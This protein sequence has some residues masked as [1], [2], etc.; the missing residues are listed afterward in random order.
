MRVTGYFVIP[1][2]DLNPHRSKDMRFFSSSLCR[3]VKLLLV[4]RIGTL[5]FATIR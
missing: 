1:V 2:G 5:R 4:V 3:T